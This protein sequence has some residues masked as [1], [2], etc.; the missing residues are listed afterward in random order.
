MYYN[1][2]WITCQLKGLLAK[3][4]FAALVQDAIEVFH[5]DALT[6]FTVDF[7]GLVYHHSVLNC[8]AVLD[9]AGLHG[10]GVGEQAQVHA[11]DSFA[12]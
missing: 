6:D 3:V 9:T 2:I 5:K 8:T 11:V 10:A 7:E 4:V 1:S 12:F